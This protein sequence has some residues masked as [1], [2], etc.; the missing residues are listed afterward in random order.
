MTTSS[1]RPHR[2]GSNQIL[3]YYA[4]GAKIAR[5]RQE[6]GK[7]GPED[8]VGS[9]TAIPLE[10]LPGETDPTVGISRLPDGTLLRDAMLGEPDG[11]LGRE[12]AR[13]FDGTPGLLVK[14]LDAGTRLPVHCHPTRETARA[15]LGSRYGKTEGW[16]VLDADPGAAI[17]LGFREPV[18]LEQLALWVDG[19]NVDEMLAAMNRL[20]AHPGD[21]FYVPAGLPHSIGEGIMI[22][23]VQEPTSFSV[24]AEYRA[25]GLD[26]NQATLGLGWAEALPF[27]DLSGYGADRLGRLKIEP[28]RVADDAGGTLWRLYPVEAEEFFQAFRA[29]VDGDLGLGAPMFRV[30]IVERGAGRLSWDG[31]E[32]EVSSGETWVVPHGA[33]ELTARGEIEAIL[34]CPPRVHRFR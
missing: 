7:Q 26:E 34:C 28:T 20:E 16:I 13:A 25:F 22:A 24:L 33:G 2:L 1:T 30:L 11:W 17:W 6:G 14:L 31:G 32:V 12:L 4:G 29:R 21:V 15:K 8:W 5:F 19:Q 10:L 3:L 23:E 18:E 9:V 27:F